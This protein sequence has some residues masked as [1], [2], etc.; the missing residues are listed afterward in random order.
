MYLCN[1]HKIV[2]VHTEY[3]SKECLFIKIDVTKS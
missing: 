3:Y 1:T 2:L